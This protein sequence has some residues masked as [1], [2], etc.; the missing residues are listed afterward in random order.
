MAITV[1]V[2]CGHQTEQHVSY[3][4]F[5]IDETEFKLTLDD[6]DRLVEVDAES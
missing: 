5:L 6:I 2:H 4:Q 1:L 3:I